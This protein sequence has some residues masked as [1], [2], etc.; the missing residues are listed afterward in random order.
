MSPRGFQLGFGVSLVLGLVFGNTALAAGPVFLG[1]QYDVG[2]APCSVA[3][4]DLNGDDVPDLVVANWSYPAAG[5]V[6]VLLNNGD[7]SFAAAVH[8]DAGGRPRSIAVGDLNGDE[9]LDLA[10][11]NMADVNVSVLLNDGDGTF[12]APVSY[13]AI[14]CPFTVAVG[15]LNGDG[16]LDL[17]VANEW[18]MAITPHDNNV[19]V[20]LNNGDGTFAA[21]VHYEAEPYTRSL[22]I[23][24]LDGDGWLDL[25]VAKSLDATVS[26][27][28]NNGDGTFAGPLHYA[29]GEAHAVAVG[30][31]N[32]DGW[33]DLVVANRS[34][35]KIA[36]LL[37]NGDGTFGAPLQYD[38]GINP[39]FVAV[40][41]LDADE[42][43]DLAVANEG[44]D[45]VSV[46]VNNG[47]GTFHAQGDH[48]V[49]G[50]PC[51]VAIG[52]LDGD[53]WL[54]LAVA[55]ADSDSV[56]VLV[57]LGGELEEIC[58]AASTILLVLTLV[59]LVKSRR[60]RQAS[61]TARRHGPSVR[62][63]AN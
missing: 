28:L 61:R 5:T 39:A 48:P 13:P 49:G 34:D 23:G 40:G 52:D 46:L 19:S 20:L 1:E 9:W 2:V 33:L 3:V 45:N 30:D 60:R 57:N 38:A 24:D 32:G 22:A 26:V 8:Y 10:V 54:D 31:L 42:W 6:S 62:R 11:T 37:N 12:G 21:P 14:P 59:G 16:W 29:S 53:G 41:N 47:N 35:H 50:A 18:V 44:S 27:L 43:P 63:G 58:P 51:S 15:D 36:V 7:G 56:S 55:N 4:G 25:A 17:A